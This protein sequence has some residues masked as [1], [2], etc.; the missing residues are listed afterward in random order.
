MSKHKIRVGVMTA[1]DEEEKA[2]DEMVSAIGNAILSLVNMK[3]KV[4]QDGHT[5]RHVSILFEDLEE[6]GN[7]T[8]SK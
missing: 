8:L 1:P 2:D 7:L 5:M 6:P 3:V 4:F